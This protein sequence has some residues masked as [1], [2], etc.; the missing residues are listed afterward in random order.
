VLQRLSPL[1][2]AAP[3]AFGRLLAALDFHLG[4]PVEIALVG[5]LPATDTQALLREVRGRYLPDRLLAQTSGA[6]GGGIPLLDGKGRVDGRATAYLCE[7]FACRA[8]ATDPA[9]LG[10][11]LDQLTAR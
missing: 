6:D 2:A 8:P 3:A 10:R 7:G 9:E 4:R 11:Q 5:D 1:A